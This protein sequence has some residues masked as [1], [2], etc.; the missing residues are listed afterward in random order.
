MNPSEDVVA[1]VVDQRNSGLEKDPGPEV[2]ISTRYR[3][4]GVHDCCGAGLHEGFRAH[5]IEIAVMDDRDL[6][7][8]PGAS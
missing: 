1:H 3:G 5:P 6:A 4:H 7:R 2:G 8:S